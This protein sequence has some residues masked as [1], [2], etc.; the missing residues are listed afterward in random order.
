MFAHE[1]EALVRTILQAERDE[2]MATLQDLTDKFAALETAVSDALE[3]VKMPVE[4]TPAGIT[5]AELDPIAAK[6]D[7]LRATVDGVVAAHTA[8]AP[9]GSTVG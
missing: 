3:I 9:A 7:E 6:L 4:P 2:A 5:E 1:V 8:P